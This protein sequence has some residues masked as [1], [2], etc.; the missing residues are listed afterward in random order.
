M[1][2]FLVLAAFAAVV[3]PAAP[4]DACHNSVE[5]VVD[6]TNRSVR[7]AEQLLADGAH[8][9]AVKEV[10]ATFPEAVQLT[11]RARRPGL[12][13]RAQRV[14][15]LAAV[16]SGGGVRLASHMSGKTASHRTAALAWSAMLLRLHHA[17]SDDVVVRAE[18][19]EALAALPAERAGAYALLKELGDGDVLPTARAW[20]LLAEL[21]RDRG[22]AT[23]AERAGRRC[24]EIA[25]DD[26]V[27]APEPPTS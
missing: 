6:V 27:C 12:F 8:A 11:H 14:L 17:R 10:L 4:A 23:A 9:A 19:A 24:R 7:R 5:R 25:P 3:V 2:N 16:R 15:A 1:R 21:E 13:A 26:P 22:D 18:L 20:A